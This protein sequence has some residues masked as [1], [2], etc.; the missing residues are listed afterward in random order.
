MLRAVNWSSKFN[1][2][3]RVDALVAEFQFIFFDI[4]HSCTPVTKRTRK[5]RKPLPKS[6]LRLINKKQKYWHKFEDSDDKAPH[7]L[8]WHQISNQE[9]LRETGIRSI[10]QHCRRNLFKYVNN[11]VGKKSKPIEITLSGGSK[12]NDHAASL[13]RRI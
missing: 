1:S 12:S 10:I 8:R 2:L 7:S 13:W 6:I 9:V 5:H 11:T 4:L 3:Q